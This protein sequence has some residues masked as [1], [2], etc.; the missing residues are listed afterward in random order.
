MSETRVQLA[1][2][3]EYC[4]HC[5]GCT[6]A[7]RDIAWLLNV[8]GGDIDFVPVVLS[9]L[10]MTRERCFW[11]VRPEAVPEELR[12]TLAEEGVEL[13]PYDGIYDYI[14]GLRSGEKVMM[15][16]SAVN[17]RLCSSLPAGVILR[18]QINPSVLLKAVKNE[19][20]LAATRQAHLKDAVVMVKFIYWLKKYVGV[21]PMTEISA[22]DKLREIASRQP[23]FLAGSGGCP[24]AAHGTGRRG[25]GTGRGGE[26]KHEAPPGP[27]NHPEDR[28]DLPG[29]LPP[30][31]LAA[32]APSVNRRETSRDPRHA[33]PWSMGRHMDRGSPAIRRKSEG[34][35]PA[36][37]FAFSVFDD[38]R[39]QAQIVLDEDAPGLLVSL[40]GQGQ[41][42]PLLLCPQRPGE[43]SPAQAEHEE[44]G[45][46]Q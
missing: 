34:K 26:G 20:E 39:H 37:P 31:R 15:D 41:V 3:P 30:G 42:V 44:R 38:V 14:A 33:S 2:A 4:R 32:G 19:T 9:Y 28:G 18:D 27:G 25:A 35:R 5:F 22:A 45:I 12:K 21:L 11:F 13:R 24:V 43:G 16:G 10:A 8:R 1:W 17:Y 36:F 6:A 29:P 40:G 7:C 46:Q 23:G